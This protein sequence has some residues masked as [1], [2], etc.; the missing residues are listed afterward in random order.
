M[1]LYNKDWDKKSKVVSLADF[2]GWLEE[3]PPAKPY[4]YDDT[5]GHCLVGQY[6]AARGIEWNYILRPE[7]SHYGKVIH[8]LFGDDPKMAGYL[9]PRGAGERDVLATRP[10]TFGGALKRAKVFQE[11]KEKK[12]A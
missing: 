1:M 6:M 12:N 3:Q 2:I 8:Q 4:S 5:H 9:F 10:Q 7:E 11:Q